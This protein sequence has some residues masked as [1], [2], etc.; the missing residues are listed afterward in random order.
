MGDLRVKLLELISH[1]VISQVVGRGSD[2]PFPAPILRHLLWLYAKAYRVNLDEA[3]YPLDAYRS[4]N[5]FF[6]RP[7]RPGARPIASAAIVSPTDGKL[8]QFGKL[9]RGELVQAKGIRYSVD[10]LLLG[11]PR[12]S[13]YYDGV[14]FNVYLSPRDYHRVHAPVTGKVIGFRY[15]PGRLFPVN[16]LAV[17]TVP[18]LFTINERLITYLATELGTVAI[19]MIGATSVGR[20][21]VVYSD[22]TTNRGDGE[23]FYGELEEDL[24]LEAGDELGRFNLGSTVVVLIPSQQLTFAQLSPGQTVRLGQPVAH[25]PS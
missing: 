2:L 24:V 3:A 14:Y 9:A 10:D 20:M 1:N 17:N 23:P 13:T 16:P 4:F 25:R 22:F 18:A 5:E 11:C 21:S 12:A 19:V 6:V 8:A 15:I 7:L